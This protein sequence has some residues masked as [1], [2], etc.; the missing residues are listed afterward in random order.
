MVFIL[1][2]DRTLKAI[3]SEFLENNFDFSKIDTEYGVLFKEIRIDIFIENLTPKRDFPKDSWIGFIVEN[4]RRYII[5]ELKYVGSKANF[6][7]SR[8]LFLYKTILAE[9]FDC[10]Y[11]DIMPVLIV[12]GISRLLDRDLKARIDEKLSLSGGR[13]LYRVVGSRA[14]EMLIIA[15]DELDISV[16]YNE[17]LMLFSSRDD[18]SVMAAMEILR[19]YSVD[20]FLY[21]FAIIYRPEVS[22]MAKT[23]LVS[24]EKLA[25]AIHAIGL[26]KFVSAVDAI[27]I[28]KLAEALGPEKMAKMIEEVG[29]DKLAEALGPEKMAKIVIDLIK[30]LPKDVREKLLR[31]IHNILTQ[32]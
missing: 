6:R 10:D 21:A 22:R 12:S 4:R 17:V 19:R 2:Y 26:D 11:S 14:F 29:I 30:A 3:I 23:E 32:P 7:M 16:A 31:E 27:G 20:T 15:V 9:K 13:G 8:R 24:P 25:L 5:I 18:L 1:A 28:D